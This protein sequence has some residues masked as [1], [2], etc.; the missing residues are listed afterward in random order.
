MLNPQIKKTIVDALIKVVD[1]APN[2]SNRQYNSD[3]SRNYPRN[4]YQ[5]GGTYRPGYTYQSDM[6]YQSDI[7]NENFEVWINYVFSVLKITA[8]QINSNLS[9]TVYQQIQNIVYQNNRNN[10]SKTIDICRI[11]LDYAQ[12]IL[13]L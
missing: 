3:K 5:A 13:K 12:N 9:Y 6:V 2:M 11:L 7:S 10:S 1:S 4:Y 8:Q